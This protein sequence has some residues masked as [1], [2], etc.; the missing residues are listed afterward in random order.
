MRHPQN[1]VC[2]PVEGSQPLP[3]CERC[4][5]QTPVADLNGGHHH[6]ELCRRGWERKRQHAAAVRSQE[7]L[8]QS[9][10]AYGEELERVEVFKYLGRLIAYDDADNQAMRLNLRKAWGCWARILHVLRAENATARTCG[11]FYKATLQA[12]LLYGSETWNMSPTSVK[13]L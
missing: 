12:V 5:L 8:K 9:F 2:F 3:K 1:L 13:R 6:T 11:M 10:T 7:A 4:G